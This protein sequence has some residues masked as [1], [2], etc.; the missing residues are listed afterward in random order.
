MIEH[1]PTDE[2]LLGYPAGSLP[3]PMEVI[4]AAHMSLCP[5]CR[6]ASARFEA[7]GGKLFDELEGDA[8]PAGGVDDVFARLDRPE[9]APPPAA[10]SEDP[11]TARVL[12]APLRAMAAAPLN[13][14]SW[15]DPLSG[16]SVVDL[17]SIE[18]DG[19]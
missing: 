17:A 19:A 5:S 12:P 4:V 18:K 15:R 1:H 13:S 9:G 2:F 11:D 3:Y 7:L 14:L 6:A 8:L 16:V 10:A